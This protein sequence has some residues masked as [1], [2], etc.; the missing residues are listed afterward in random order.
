M[1]LRNRPSHAAQ[2]GNHHAETPAPLLTPEELTA[3]VD[4]DYQH[5]DYNH[6]PLTVSGLDHYFQS[7]ESDERFHIS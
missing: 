5:V 3:I 1:T 7:P 2:P 4:A 6:Q